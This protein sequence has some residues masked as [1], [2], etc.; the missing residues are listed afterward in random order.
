MFFFIC[1]EINASNTF[2]KSWH[3]SHKGQKTCAI[4]IKIP[5]KDCVDKYLFNSLTATFVNSK[6]AMTLGILLSMI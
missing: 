1:F 4:L 6:I 5:V 3:K 2:Q